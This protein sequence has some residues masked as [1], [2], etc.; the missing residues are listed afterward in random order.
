MTPPAYSGATSNRDR[1]AATKA[2]AALALGGF[3]IGVTEFATMGL[4]PQIAASFDVSIPATGHAI[5]FYALGVV[6]GAPL[7]VSLAARL[8]RKGLMIGLMVALA[9]GNALSAVAPSAGLLVAARFLAGLPHGAYF[10]I[11][12]VVA[13]A[14]VPP[15]RRGRAVAKI[16]IGLT[17]ANLGGVP[18]AT[19]VGQQAGWRSAYWAVT[20]IAVITALAVHRHVPRIAATRDAGVLGELRAFGRIQVWFALFT[21]MIGFG[22]MFAVYSYISP[23][24]TEVTG[25]PE[26][27]VPWMLAVFGL[28]QTVGALVGGRF[29]DR[30]VPGS[31]IGSLI[32]SALVLALFG[33]TAT[34][35]VPAVAS[36]FLIG[37]TSQVLAGALQVHLMD[38]SPDAPSLASASNHSALNI[39]NAAGAW[40]GG[41]AITA[42][43]GYASTAWVGVALS[44]T[45]LAVAL[46]SVAVF[47]VS[48]RRSSSPV[49]VG[50]SRD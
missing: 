44:L 32:A 4:V 12:A 17:V 40:L 1:R 3:G 47:R 41:L 14:L 46:I 20:V 9:A 35:P 18:I 19:A 10:G 28:G 30:S 25:L 37:F 13:A 36:V 45:G 26:S 15:G 11:A 23:T 7:I 33:L 21:G 5:T 24:T 48:R 38:A 27:A 43:W 2:L 49:T 34:L 8:P 22:G 6:V 42:G 29:V 50:R 31:V 39:A 16:M